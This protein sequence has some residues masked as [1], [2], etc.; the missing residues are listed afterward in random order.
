MKK[1][2]CLVICMCF[3]GTILLFPQT[4]KIKPIL[5]SKL[6]IGDGL[7]EFALALGDAKDY[8]WGPSALFFAKNDTLAVFDQAQNRIK[9]YSLAGKLLEDKKLEK[10]S[11]PPFLDEFE[12]VTFIE[13]VNNQMYL[14]AENKIIYKVD[15]DGKIGI[16]SFP[17]NLGILDCLFFDNILFGWNSNGDI[18]CIPNASFSSMR[19]ALNPYLSSEGIHLFLQKNDYIK[20]SL[21]LDKDNSLI[22]NNKPMLNS[23]W[24]VIKYFNKENLHFNNDKNNLFKLSPYD[25]FLGVDNDGNIYFNRNLSILIIDKNGFVKKIIVPDVGKSVSYSGRPIIHPKGD[26]YFIGTDA[27]SPPKNFAIYR[28]NRFW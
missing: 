6:L 9:Y 3:M 23:T 1:Y 24:Q 28:I 27:V 21:T 17:Y 14:H 8:Y 25:V 7:G 13:V 2:L 18:F 4:Q 19:D 20:Q 11:L 16:Y 5:I 22:Y 10:F 12:R 15:D 26:I